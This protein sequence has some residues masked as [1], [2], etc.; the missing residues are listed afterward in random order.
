M[1]ALR[2]IVIGNIYFKKLQKLYVL[3]KPW[4]INHSLL[5]DKVFTESNRYDYSERFKGK[6]YVGL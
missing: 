4:E 6:R 5:V 2:K 3:R 1:F